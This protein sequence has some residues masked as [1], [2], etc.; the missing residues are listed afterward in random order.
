M[1]D[2]ISKKDDQKR[3]V[4]H[5]IVDRQ[6]ESYAFKPPLNLAMTRV[7]CVDIPTSQPS[8]LA[9][10]HVTNVFLYEVPCTEEPRFGH[11]FS[12]PDFSKELEKTMDKFQ[13]NLEKDLKKNLESNLVK[14]LSKVLSPPS[15]HT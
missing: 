1:K 8:N 9:N 5:I 3:K 15:Q 4:Q 6:F 2:E 13:T 11:S 7:S 10:D 14:E 12:V